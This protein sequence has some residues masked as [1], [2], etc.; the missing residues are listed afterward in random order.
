MITLTR[1]LRL[2]LDKSIIDIF[3]LTCWQM[4]GISDTEILK[5]LTNRIAAHRGSTSEARP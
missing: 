4:N 5:D 1:I 2:A 3:T